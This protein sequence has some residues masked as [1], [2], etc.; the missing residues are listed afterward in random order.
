MQ[1]TAQVVRTGFGWVWVLSP[2]VVYPPLGPGLLAPWGKDVGL[3]CQ[4]QARGQCRLPCLGLGFPLSLHQIC[5]PPNQTQT[6]SLGAHFGQ[7]TPLTCPIWCA[8]DEG[9]QH[10]HFVSLVSLLLQPRFHLCPHPLLH[11]QQLLVGELELGQRLVDE[12]V[13]FRQPV[14]HRRHH[15][16]SLPTAALRQQEPHFR[17]RHQAPG[18]FV[19]APGVPA[20]R[21]GCKTPGCVVWGETKNPQILKIY[22]AS[23]D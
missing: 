11:L 14:R 13:L 15:R 17:V 22:T 21:R 2:S 16:C 7:P 6:P 18:G 19:Q 8:T 9:G 3:V 23:M 4:Q 1:R 20:G 5:S 10:F 12:P